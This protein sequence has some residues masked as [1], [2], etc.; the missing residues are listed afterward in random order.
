MTKVLVTGCAGFIGSHLTQRLLQDGFQVTG[1]DGFL[2]NYDVAEKTHNLMEIGNHPGFTF[3]SALLQEQR[4]KEWLDGVEVVY[5]LAA[6]P[7]VRS[8]WGTAF[9]EY[10][11][12]NILATQALL[13][14]CL[15]LPKPPVIVA[16]SSSSVYGTM[17]GMTDESA[18]LQPLSPYGV[19]KQAMEQIC[20]VYVKAY[21]LPVTLLRYF[22]VYGPRQ[23]PDMAFHRFLV[24][25]LKG[26]PIPVYGDGQ[27]SRD[28][29]FVSDAVEANL[30]AARHAQPGDVF[31][32]G[33]EREIKLIDVLS[34]MGQLLHSTPNIVYHPPQ[35][36]DSQ[37][38]CADIGFARSRLGYRPTVSLEE[39]LRLQLEH[40]RTRC[41]N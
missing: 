27:Q 6:L 24:Q 39:G 37:R 2:D 18:P 10:V 22:T 36:G 15:K 35:P 28:F 16:S 7:G 29:T 23:R 13:E 21:G 1:V 26:R 5:H 4:W 8:S 14:A 3:H 34:L 19:T 20:Q 41:K 32:I 17:G 11:S 9:S 38:T 12:H 33:G 25:L 30:L 40:V 31:N